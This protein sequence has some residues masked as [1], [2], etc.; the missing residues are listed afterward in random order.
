MCVN[1][2]AH[3]TNLHMYMYALFSSTP[4]GRDLSVCLREQI[5]PSSRASGSH[6]WTTLFP[7]P[8][9]LQI[10]HNFQHNTTQSYIIQSK[11]SDAVKTHRRSNYMSE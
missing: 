6:E 10:A 8:G 7:R 2:H 3:S 5:S 1:K 4:G 9:N 11:R